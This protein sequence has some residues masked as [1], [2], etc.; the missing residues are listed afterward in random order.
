MDIIKV[1][2]FVAAAAIGA[3]AVQYVMAP[4]VNKE[5]AKAA[6][7]MNQDLPKMV[8]PVTR[9]NHVD[10]GDKS[11]QYN[12]TLTDPALADIDKSKLLDLAR[13]KLLEA[14]CK[15]PSMQPFLKNNVTATY[16]YKNASGGDILSIRITAADCHA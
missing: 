16:S 6:E 5:L 3:K 7:K 12:Y 10:T 9:L 11:I 14:Y 4:N 15:S 13:P 8:D 2:V 1:V